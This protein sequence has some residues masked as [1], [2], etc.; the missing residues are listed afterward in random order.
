MDKLGGLSYVER[1]NE[2]ELVSQHEGTLS[3]SNEAGNGEEDV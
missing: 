1:F 2:S 3:S